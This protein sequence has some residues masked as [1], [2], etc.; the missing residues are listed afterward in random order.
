MRR[1]LSVLSILLFAVFAFG[2]IGL[3]WSTSGGDG[4]DFHAIR[5]T[6]VFINNSGSAIVS[7]SVVILDTS[8]TGV[9]LG[10]YVTTTT[11]DDDDLAVGVTLTVSAADGLPLVVVT[12][13]AVDAIAHPTDTWTAGT[14]VGTSGVA[15]QV[16]TGE[17]LGI[18][19]ESTST[20]SSAHHRI[21]VA[22]N[23][24]N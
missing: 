18:A 12:K 16:G 8:A 17:N 20:G 10:S 7:G 22:P 11:G 2:R 15:G 1:K 24:A 5:E 3:P 23:N 6:A 4:Q 9:N 14:P 21:W 13:G 19:L